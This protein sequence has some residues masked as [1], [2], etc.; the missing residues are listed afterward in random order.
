MR[1]IRVRLRA[2]AVY[3]N[4]SLPFKLKRDFSKSFVAALSL[5]RFPC[6]TKHLAWHNLST[7]YHLEVDERGEPL[8]L[9]PRRLG[10][11]A[12]GACQRHKT[13]TQTG[14]SSPKDL[15]GAT[16]HTGYRNADP[17]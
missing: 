6:E 16:S 4:A 15:I 13:L 7:E 8:E 2:A 17:R 10:C 1:L 12:R 14:S 3:P 11:T 9:G 5:L